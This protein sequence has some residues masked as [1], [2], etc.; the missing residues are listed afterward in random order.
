MIGM[1]HSISGIQI[2]KVKP[3]MDRIGIDMHTIKIRISFNRN[4]A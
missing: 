2:K 1:L 3:K 4:S